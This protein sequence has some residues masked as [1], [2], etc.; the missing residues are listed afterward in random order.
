MTDFDPIPLLIEELNL[1]KAKIAA[2]I[3]LLL[4]GNTIPFIAR[5]R[6]EMTGNLDEVEIRSIQER[7]AY[8]TELNERRQA[9]LTSIESQG[10]LTESLKKQIL[11]CTTKQALED[12]YL[13]YKPKRRTRATIAKEKGLEPLACKILE[14]SPTNPLTDAQEYVNAEKGVMSVEE[15]LSGARDIVAEILSEDAAIRSMVRDAYMEEGVVVSKVVKE[16]ANATSKFQQYYD[17]AER[18]STIP[19]HRYLA[20]RRG[21]N[22]GILEYSIEFES[23]ILIDAIKRQARLNPK[24]GYAPELEKAVTDSFKRL[25]T[26]SVETDVRVELKIKSDRGAVDVFADNLRNLL[27]A[28]PL[29]EKSVIGIDPGIRSGC[30]CVAVDSTGKFLDTV[31]I[32]PSQGDR[33]EERARH[34]FMEFLLKHKPFAIGIGNGTAGRETEAFVK[35]LLSDAK[36]KEIIVIQV[37]EAG[38]SVYSASDVAREE[39]PELDLTIRGAISI[40]RRLQDP[41]AELVKIDPKAIGVGQYQHDVYQQLLQD[42]LHEVVESCVN[43]VGVELNTA[44]A[45]LLSY[46]AGIGP[47][48]ATKIVKHRENQGAFTS[49]KQILD[50]SGMGAK[51]YEQAA[52]FLRVREGLHPLDASAV[53]PERYILVEQM[54]KDIEVDLKDLIGNS[55]L[56]QRI[57]LKRYISD[58]IGEPTLKDIIAELQKPGRDPRTAFEKPCFR[59][60][61]RSPKDLKE[62]MQLEGIVTNV[63]AF[64]AFVDIGVHQ[65]GLVHVSELTDRF[66]KDPSEVV[67]VG[68]KI[69]VRVV[70]VDLD[71]NRIALSAKK[72]GAKVGEKVGAK[73]QQKPAPQKKFNSNPFANL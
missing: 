67:H 68:D 32:Y 55:G 43:H 28:S 41:L 12:L 54:A 17:F 37:N 39:F 18:V 70:S 27:L 57:E 7:L 61:I 26:P 63:T 24:S 4:E 72:G 42:K 47:S 19:S 10:K 71:R 20:I 62:G 60:D 53:H 65:D 22:E 30:K 23:A 2:V 69:S 38:A 8:L 73:V 16:H 1:P 52:G 35:D 5:Y 51:T 21:E 56:I 66:I 31:T 11:E 48:L 25:L 9:I 29:G 15:A 46:V 50:V 34:D 40:A 6:K 59:D 13:P 45:S 64:G 14:Q 44:S 33:S 49:R 3:K 58:S 36:I